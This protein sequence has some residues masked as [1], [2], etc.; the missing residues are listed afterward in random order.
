MNHTEFLVH[1]TTTI[2]I[3]YQQIFFPFLSSS[4]IQIVVAIC[5]ADVSNSSLRER[6]TYTT[7]S[8]LVTKKMAALIQTQ[9]QGACGPT[10]IGGDKVLQFWIDILLACPNWYRERSVLHLLDTLCMAAH[11]EVAW[12]NALQ[13]IMLKAYKVCVCV[14]VGVVWC[15]VM[16]V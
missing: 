9:L 16:C 5:N 4:F 1:G 12:Q 13:T 2:R 15:G 6:W 8:H 11:S 10:G 14:C 3:C 7:P